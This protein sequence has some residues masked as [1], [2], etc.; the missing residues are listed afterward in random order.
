[1]KGLLLLAALCV[2]C[3]FIYETERPSSVP[4]NLPSQN[5]EQESGSTPTVPAYSSDSGS[6][7]WGSGH[8]A[9]YDWAEEN[10][11]D[12]EGVCETAG[13]NHNSP[14]FAE[15]CEAYVDGESH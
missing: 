5:W 2:A 14:S 10:D 3:V 9:G 6:T 15:G 4:S 8:Q 13:D 12:D 7:A 11:I 1:M